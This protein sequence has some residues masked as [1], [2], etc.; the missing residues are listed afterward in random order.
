MKTLF[1]DESGQAIL[2]FAMILPVFILVGFGLVDMQWMTKQAANMDYIVNEVSRCEAMAQ[3][4]PS[5]AL[6]CNPS[7]GGVSPHQYAMNLARDLRLDNAQLT[8]NA[9][10]CDPTLGTCNVIAIYDY[11]ALGV[12]FPAV[13]I[14]R[15]GTASYIP[16]P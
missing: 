15:T 10:N 7:A 11:H 5:V 13:T 9:P 12:W 3:H 8:I 16:A 4:S 14:R 1:S 2:E 6:P